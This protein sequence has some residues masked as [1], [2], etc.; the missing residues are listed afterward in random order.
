MRILHLSTYDTHGGASRAAYRIHKSLPGAGVESSM[1]V[2]RKFSSDD[3]VYVLKSQRSDISL[4]HRILSK[5][6]RLPVKFYNDSQNFSFPLFQEK[7]KNSVLVNSAD[8]VNLHWILYGFVRPDFLA[9]LK[10][11]IIWTLH[12]MWPFTGGCFYC[13]ECSKY[14]DKCGNCPVLNSKHPRDLSYWGM[15]FKKRCWDNIDLTI[16]SPSR[17]L[18]QCAQ[19]STLFK[20][21]NIRII[22]YGID[23]D[24]FKPIQKETARE[25]LKLPPD[26]K[27][28]SLGAVVTTDKRKGYQYLTEAVRNNQC[29]FDV[30]TF[31]MQDKNNQLN[32]NTTVYD[33][34]FVKNDTLLSLIY[35][36]SDLMV[37]P[38][39]YE[40]LPQTAIEAMA[41]A[42]PVVAFNATGLPDVVEHK[43]T[44]YLAQ[45]YDANDLYNGIAWVLEDENRLNELSSNAVERVKTN[46]TYAVQSER[47]VELYKEILS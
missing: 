34:G 19:K 45:P 35:S 43:K 44:G 13:G 3:D 4:K 24:V 15:K 7:L 29:N 14:E 8:I 33:M 21:K 22:P 18:G 36:A 20:D 1:L 47:Y 46:F 41:C 30:L 31:G 12:D 25:I 27:I 38:S 42:T 17:W 11:P 9:D 16:V 2:S 10:K 6:E 28:I 32:I 23:T 37:V 26:K 39:V 40:N 5:I